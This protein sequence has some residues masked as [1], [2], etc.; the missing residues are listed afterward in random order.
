MT[1]DEAVSSV[2]RLRQAGV[3]LESVHFHLGQRPQNPHAYSRAVAAVIDICRAA[4]FRPRFVDCGGG[5]PAPPCADL[6]LAGLCTA[7]SE[8]HAEFSPEL[9]EVWLENG[10]FVTVA[11]LP[12]WTRGLTFHGRIAF[13]GTSRVLPRFR[14]YAPGLDVDRSHCGIHAVDTVSGRVLGSLLW[15]WGNQI[16]AVDGVP[17]AFASGFPFTAGARRAAR[18]ETRLF[19]A[20][21]TGLAGEGCKR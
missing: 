4:A 19:Y 8:I 17:V 14:Q 3:D 12:G 18:R 10:R 21:V 1:P 6:A 11:R 16:F 15:P 20:F 13:V 5:L 7:I 2:Q 9:E